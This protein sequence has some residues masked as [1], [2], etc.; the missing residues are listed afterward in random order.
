MARTLPAPIL[1][2]ILAIEW[3]PLRTHCTAGDSSDFDDVLATERHEMERGLAGEGANSGLP[4]AGE[5][6]C[7]ARPCS[8]EGLAAGH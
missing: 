6:D 7:E 1:L 2:L 4:A 5:G 8:L 3:A